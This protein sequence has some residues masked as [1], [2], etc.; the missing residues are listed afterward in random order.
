M[1]HGSNSPEMGCAGAFRACFEALRCIACSTAIFLP[2]LAPVRP[3]LGDIA[4]PAT[5]VLQQ[6]YVAGSVHEE[7]PS[8]PDTL[9]GEPT[10]QEGP[11][12]PPFLAR[13]RG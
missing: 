7:P 4:P 12:L 6:F 2:V 13:E 10:E 11:T 1:R 8:Q 3:E 5:T 9:R